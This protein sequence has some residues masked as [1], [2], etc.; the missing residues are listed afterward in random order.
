MYILR[1]NKNTYYDLK[2]KWNLKS[3]EI[4]IVFNHIIFKYKNV[5]V[6]PLHININITILNILLYVEEYL[7]ICQYF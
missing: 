6:I 2:K 7:H 3:F 5:Y 4:K 1:W